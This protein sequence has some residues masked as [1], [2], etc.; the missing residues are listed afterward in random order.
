MKLLASN[1]ADEMGLD[2]KQ[3][4]IAENSR[5]SSVDVKKGQNLKVL[6]VYEFLQ[7]EMGE[8][9]DENLT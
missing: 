2:R 7:P 3:I 8:G 4:E 9:G 1:F 6:P 5:R